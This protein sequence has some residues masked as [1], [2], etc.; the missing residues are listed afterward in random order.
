MSWP[1]LALG[2]L[3]VLLLLMVRHLRTNGLRHLE[4]RLDR[5]ETLMVEHLQW[6]AE[7]K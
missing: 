2:L 4:E 5:I 7:G 6:H 1:E 3:N